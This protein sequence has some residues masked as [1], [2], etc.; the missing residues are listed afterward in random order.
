MTD[1]VVDHYAGS[2]DLTSSIAAALDAAG[3]EREGMTTAVLPPV[4]EFHIRGRAATVEI[5]EALKVDASSRVLDIGSGLGGPARTI[6]EVADAHVTGV[7]LTPAFAATA[8]DLSV[9]TGLSSRTTFLVGDATALEF[10]DGH[11]DAALTVHVGMNVADKAAMY[12]EAHRVLKPRGRFV[13][14]DV[15]Q[16]EGGEVNYPV[17]WARSSSTSFLAT[18]AEMTEFLRGAGFAVLDAIDS[19]AESLAWF[20]AMAARLAASGP[21]PVTFAAF[22]GGD[23]REMARNQVTN[24]RDHRIET[25]TFVCEA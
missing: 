22:L 2:D 13:V 25:V 17:P 11:F 5:I 12:R 19:S 8:S 16:G 10:P 24:L 7:D 14:Y 4:D 1:P 21:P 6:A 18:R 20:E 3:I 23:F 9:W 15:L